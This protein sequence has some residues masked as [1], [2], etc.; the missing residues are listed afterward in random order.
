M[1]LPF[2]VFRAMDLIGA[3]G[4]G[5]GRLVRDKGP[6]TV[7]FCGYCRCMFDLLLYRLFR[8]RRVIGL[9]VLPSLGTVLALGAMAGETYP[10][11]MFLA[12]LIPVAHAVLY[13][14][15]WSETLTVSLVLAVCLGLAT[16][17]PPGLPW[18]S[19]VMRVLALII[20]FLVLF[21][22]LIVPL[23]Y[24]ATIGPH[25]F[26]PHRATATS[27]LGAD[28][29]RKELTFYPGRKDARV[30]CGEPDEEGRFPVTTRLFFQNAT[31]LDE[32][33][34]AQ[35][36]ADTAIHRVMELRGHAFIHSSGPDHQ[37]TFLYEDG[38]QD[39]V[40]MR[41]TFEAL[42]D[43]GTRIVLEEAGQPMTMGQRFGMWVNDYMADH[44]THCI[45]EAE[46]RRARANRA[47]VHRQFVVD[48]A[49]VLVP[50]MNRVG[51]QEPGDG[52]TR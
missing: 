8:T 4:F 42:A 32:A 46:G 1:S 27:K 21:L 51:L 50:L 26:G 30:T 9:C 2:R 15:C 17:N 10:V 49:N 28:E 36:E 11:L 41:H 20:L 40:V 12:V 23:D 25:G 3:F 19:L 43:G 16:L 47:F 52:R 5:G 24:L 34:S 6:K 45:D 31:C 14:N 33:E 39:I 38:G 35:G 13:P 7:K 22:I 37:E 44:L 18:D 29:V 48:I